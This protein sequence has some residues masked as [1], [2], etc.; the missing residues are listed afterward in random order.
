MQGKPDWIFVKIH[1]HGRA[2]TSFR[3]LLGELLVRMH[4]YL[5]YQYNNGEDFILHYVTAREMYNLVKA[6]EAGID[7]DPACSA[8]T[9]SLP[10]PPRHRRH[11]DATAGFLLKTGHPPSVGL[12][13]ALNAVAARRILSG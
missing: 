13:P 4:E 7:L 5:Q 6:A 2:E 11:P 8:I 1:T 9:F 3:N 10:H 12:L